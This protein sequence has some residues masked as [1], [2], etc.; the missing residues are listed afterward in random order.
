[1]NG[2]PVSLSVFP[3]GAQLPVFQTYLVDVTCLTVGFPTRK[4]HTSRDLCSA[5]FGMLGHSVKELASK[6]SL[7]GSDIGVVTKHRPKLSSF[8]T[9]VKTPPVRCGS[10]P[11][12]RGWSLVHVSR[13]L[14]TWSISVG[15]IVGHSRDGL[16]PCWTLHISNRQ[17]D[18]RV[19]FGRHYEE[20][21][22]LTL[23]LTRALGDYPTVT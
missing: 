9:A 11:F 16:S 2:L 7:R 4:I 8:G 6:V 21:K 13:V 14:I 1:V 18:R 23:T 20:F 3:C 15:M 10:T 17:G 22:P 5:S 12:L 19:P